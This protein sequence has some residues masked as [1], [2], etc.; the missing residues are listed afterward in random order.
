MRRSI[1]PV[2]CKSLVFA[3]F[4]NCF[5]FYIISKS[6]YSLLQILPNMPPSENITLRKI[7]EDRYYH[8]LVPITVPVTIVAVRQLL[9]IVSKIVIASHLRIG[10]WDSVHRSLGFRRVLLTHGYPSY[11]SLSIFVVDGPLERHMSLMQHTCSCRFSWIGSVWSCSNT[12]LEP[13][14]LFGRR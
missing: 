14:S 9:F 12:I 10:L 7:Q 3:V 2:N 5:F 6:P 11:Y 13:L 1:N 4:Q 8:L